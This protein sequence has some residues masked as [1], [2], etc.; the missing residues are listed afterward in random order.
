MGEL[1]NDSPISGQPNLDEIYRQLVR[2]FGRE[3]VTDAN[4]EA[5]AERARQDGHSVLAE[6][7][8]Q[9]TQQC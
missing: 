9:W 7:L 3:F 1:V 8:H 5:L 2:G 6:E 4:A